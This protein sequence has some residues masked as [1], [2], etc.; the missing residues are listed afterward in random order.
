[1]DRRSRH[2][3][4]SHTVPQEPP[5]HSNRKGGYHARNYPSRFPEH[6]FASYQNLSRL[7]SIS[8]KYKKLKTNVRRR[9]NEIVWR[10]TIYSELPCKR[11]NNEKNY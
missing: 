2:A 8:G 4:F 3:D 11:M 5:D 6:S 1:M 7:G 10:L 9:S